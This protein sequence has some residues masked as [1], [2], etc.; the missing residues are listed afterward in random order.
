M[1]ISED[2]YNASAIQTVTVVTLTA[3][4]RRAAQPGNVAIPAEISGL[5]NESVANVTQLATVDRTALGERVGALPA[6]L[7]QQIDDGLRRALA[8]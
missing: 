6:W 5:S 7:M 4:A 1:V 8:L 2:R 3:N